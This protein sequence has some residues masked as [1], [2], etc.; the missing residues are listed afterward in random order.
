MARA[1]AAAAQSGRRAREPLLVARGLEVRLQAAGR[2]LDGGSPFLL[3]SLLAQY[4]R[5]HA[6]INAFVETT[7]TMQGWDRPLVWPA[8]PGV[9]PAG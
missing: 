4:L 8:Q 7:L 9:R 2:G 3:G 6:S 1:V 5:A